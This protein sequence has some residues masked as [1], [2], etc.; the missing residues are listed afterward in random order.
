MVSFP[1]RVSVRAHIYYIQDDLVEHIT[2][3]SL[4]F[5]PRKQIGYVTSEKS[6]TIKPLSSFAFWIGCT[7]SADGE[8][9]EVI[10]M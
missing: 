9:K 4:H 5:M 7:V 8:L 6:A 2:G 10:G 1:P 3:S